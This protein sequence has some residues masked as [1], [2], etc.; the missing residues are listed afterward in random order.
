MGRYVIRRLLHVIPVL[1]I[2]S[3]LTIAMLRLAPGDPAATLAGD[4]ATPEQ[5]EQIRHNMRLDRP[6][7]VQY[8][9]FMRDALQGDLGRSVKTN[10]AVTD[11]LRARMKYTGMLA[12]S[13]MTFAIVIG[14]TAG[15]VSAARHNSWLDNSLMMGVVAGYSLPSFWIGLMLMMLFGVRLG[16]LPFVGADSWKNLILPTLTLGTGPAAVIARLTRSSMVEVINLDYI[17][18]AWAKGLTE[19]VVVMRHALRNALIP[20]ITVV[21]LQFGGLLGGAVVTE[22]I[23][24]WPGLGSLAITSINSR[25]YP[26]VQGVVLLAA[27]TF[28]GVNLLVDL[29][30]GLL[31]PRIRYE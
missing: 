5:I 16:W 4:T 3:F 12:L 11:E 22:S 20:V 23:F 15:V 9:L 19:R 17:R 26:M 25:D 1:I 24:A 30:Y 10:R 18:T 29:V 27:I 6:I 28:V 21:G 14:I 2:I 8:A 13:A 7:P 31:D